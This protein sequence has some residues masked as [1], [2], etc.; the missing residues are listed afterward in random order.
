M[1]HLIIVLCALFVATNAYSGTLSC[2]T[3]ADTEYEIVFSETDVVATIY[4]IGEEGEKEL[5]YRRARFSMA[6]ADFVYKITGQDDRVVDWDQEAD[7]FKSVDP[8]LQFLISGDEGTLDIFYGIRTQPNVF[9]DI[10]H[11]ARPAPQTLDCELL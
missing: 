1:K 11:F 4:E 8:T 7:C 6:N 3:D 2:L 5:V 10:P 9:C